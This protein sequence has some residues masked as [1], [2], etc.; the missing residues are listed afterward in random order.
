MSAKRPRYAYRVEKVINTSSEVHWDPVAKMEARRLQIVAARVAR[1]EV[2][3]H[4]R[5]HPWKWDKR[6]ASPGSVPQ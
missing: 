4:V 3:P 1:E 5:I 6:T 2:P